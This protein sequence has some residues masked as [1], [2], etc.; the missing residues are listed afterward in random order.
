MI[1]YG[2]AAI[3]NTFIMDNHP[4]KKKSEGNIK[5]ITLSFLKRYLDSPFKYMYKFDINN[6]ADYP[7]F[8]FKEKIKY[9]LNIKKLTRNI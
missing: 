4:L 9:A 7:I 8:D 1:G 2:I 3:I 5:K 6:L